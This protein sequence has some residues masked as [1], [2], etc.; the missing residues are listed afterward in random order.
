MMNPDGDGY[1]ATGVDEVVKVGRP[2]PAQSLMMTLTEL[3]MMVYATILHVVVVELEG[4]ATN[5]LT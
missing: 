3:E 2:G 5:S 1:L 4:S